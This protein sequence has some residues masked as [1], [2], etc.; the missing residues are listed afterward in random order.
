[1]C[2]NETTKGLCMW[3]EE[4]WHRN[5]A[6][7]KGLCLSSPINCLPL[8]P[9]P[10]WFYTLNITFLSRE[11]PGASACALAVCS[12]QQAW[13]NKSSPEALV[14]ESKH[15]LWCAHGMG[16]SIIDANATRYT[17]RDRWDNKNR[18]CAVKRARAQP[19]WQ[20]LERTPFVIVCFGWNTN[21]W[22]GLH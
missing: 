5:K 21:V 19:S 14:E 9:S 6:Q 20:K 16:D 7:K 3:M 11:R 18:V 10:Q 13:R 8:C 12:W 22:V 2:R 15:H 17:W 4:E 1:M